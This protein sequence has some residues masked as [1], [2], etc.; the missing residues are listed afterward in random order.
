MTSPSRPRT[1]RTSRLR[2]E[3]LEG[4]LAPA[5]LVNPT[6]V[7]YRDVDGD[8][9]TVKV[10]VG[11]LDATNFLFNTPFAD[12]GPQQLQSLILN[13]AEFQGAAVSVSAVRDPVAGGDG[14]ANVGRVA[15]AGVDLAALTVDGDLGQVDAGDPVTSSTPGLGS[16][17]VQ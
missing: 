3:P 14:F 16:L 10:T 1:R 7:T 8:R 6:T 11:T 12:P 15:A 5:V 13:A 17:T 4:R 2:L 9:V